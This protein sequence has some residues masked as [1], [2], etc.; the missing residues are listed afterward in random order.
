MRLIGAMHQN[1]QGVLYLLFIRFRNAS[2]QVPTSSLHHIKM[3]KENSLRNLNFYGIHK[4]PTMNV[5]GNDFVYWVQR[6]FM[7]INDYCRG[8]YLSDRRKHRG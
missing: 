2:K 8:S 1:M 3:T 7:F 6:R 4:V 5:I